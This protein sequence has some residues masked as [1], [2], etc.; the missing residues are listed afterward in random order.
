VL[1]LLPTK[2]FTAQLCKL[3]IYKSI[4][5]NIAECDWLP[6]GCWK[7]PHKV[8][9]GD[10]IDDDDQNHAGDVKRATVHTIDVDEVNDDVAII[11]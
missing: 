1:L 10:G 6:F 8:Y 7:T 11:E 5:P 4:R 3:S 9:G 2:A